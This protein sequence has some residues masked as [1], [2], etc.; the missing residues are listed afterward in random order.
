LYGVGNQALGK[1]DQKY[2]EGF[3]MWCWRRMEI[4]R[5]DRAR[6]EEVLHGVKEGRKANCIG[7][8]LHRS[9]VLKYRALA[10][11]LWRNYFGKA[12]GPV[13]RQTAE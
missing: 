7:N 5:T 9:R 12:Y 13:V 8:I 6:S 1:V 2:A 3:E 11:T 10:C 4:R